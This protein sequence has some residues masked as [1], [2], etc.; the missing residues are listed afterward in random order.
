MCVNKNREIVNLVDNIDKQFGII[1]T[2]IKSLTEGEISSKTI[3]SIF[4]FLEEVNQFAR[5][6]ITVDH[7]KDLWK[8]KECHPNLL[9][10]MRKY[11]LSKP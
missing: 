8:L 2:V 5:K 3:E 10:F 9:K 11:S 1:D 4:E 7:I 6:K